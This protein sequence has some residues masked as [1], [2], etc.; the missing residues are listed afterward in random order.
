MALR[1]SAAWDGCQQGD[2]GQSGKSGLAHLRPRV[3]NHS[4]PL[5]PPVHRTRP[6][7]QLSG[8]LDGQQ[9]LSKQAL[10]L[11]DTVETAARLGYRHAAT[12]QPNLIV[13]GEAA[14]WG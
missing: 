5:W 4:H 11:I 8:E 1:H 14:C 12:F 3:R 9:Y 13:E 7:L 6:V 2:A 10:G